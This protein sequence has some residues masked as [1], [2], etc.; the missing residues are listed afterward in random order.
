M[1]YLGFGLLALLFLGIAIATWYSPFIREADPAG[2]GFAHREALRAGIA[3]MAATA[4]V[5]VAGYLY[6]R[7]GKPKDGPPRDSGE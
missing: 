1:K 7:Y 3:G 2:L 5:I 4:A 6:I